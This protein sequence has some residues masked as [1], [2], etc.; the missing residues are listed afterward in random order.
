MVAYAEGGLRSKNQLNPLSLVD[1]DPE[2][3]GQTDRQTD[4]I[5]VACAALPCNARRAVNLFAM[6]VER[7]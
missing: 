5:A 7:K 4:T 6:K 2:C 1:T 3:D